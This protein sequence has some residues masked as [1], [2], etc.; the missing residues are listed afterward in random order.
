MANF[1]ALKNQA[2]RLLSKL[3][4]G[5]QYHISNLNTRLR[6]AADEHPGDIVISS[7]ASIIERMYKENP[8]Q[9]VSQGEVE[10]IYQELAGL[11]SNTRFREVLG[12]LLKSEMKEDNSST[13]RNFINSVRDPEQEP[14]NDDISLVTKSG[15]NGLF[16]NTTS[17]YDP[18]RA[19]KAKNLVEL[20]LRHIGFSNPHVKIAGGNPRFLV[21]SADLDTNR[22]TVRVLVPADSNG[23]TL[24]GCFVGAFGNDG[25]GKVERLNVPNLNKYIKQSS[26]NR[27]RLPE[28]KDI[29]SAL[30]RVVG[31]SPTN[32]TDDKS[33]SLISNLPGKNG[34][35]GL[36]APG[37][38]TKLPN[39]NNVI[40]DVEIPKVPMPKELKV[41]AEE[42]EDSIKE[43]AVGFPHAS[44]RLAK[45][46]IVAELN[47]MGFKNSQVRVS[48]PTSDGFICEAVLN[49]P[50]GKLKI[51]IP[52]EMN[53]NS[54]LLP[55]VFAKNDFIANFTPANIYAVA[56]KEAGSVD[57]AVNRDNQLFASSLMEL[58]DAM[59]KA[60]IKGDLGIC[61]EVME[62]VASKF[63][64]NVHRSLVSDYCKLLSNVK[65]VDD[66]IKQ[67]YKDNQFVK[68][69][70]SI[71]PV[72]K[73]FGLPAH[74]LVK[75]SNGNWHRKSTY[76]S[77]ANNDNFN[78]GGAFFSTAKVLVGD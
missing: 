4:H 64:E 34:T 47:S 13:N 17:L 7:I 53:G 30:D 31:A 77:T 67:S 63:D 25:N 28:V 60:A 69:P 20:E 52:I 51:E 39:E 2:E 5:K 12:D 57:V 73:I 54:P 41:V 21:F 43:V 65:A 76:H 14:F 23:D 18:H 9:I 62:I 45:R 37:I 68:T 3:E 33:N 72:H 11:N 75:D 36:S 78:N 46:M 58:K 19:S 56:Y 44:V 74:E 55:S 32:I 16:D 10:K 6:T 48:E 35:E 59:Y 61:D 38:F 42:L 24:P 40:K 15:L 27:S 66:S 1:S 29:L 8:G 22:G 49:A 50:N 71:Y 70:N 26:R